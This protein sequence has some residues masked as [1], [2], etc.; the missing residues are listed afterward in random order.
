M[1]D[2]K[3]F[4]FSRTNTLNTYR[5]DPGGVINASIDGDSFV[6]A[7]ANG[8]VNIEMPGLGVGKSYLPG[9]GET[10][11]AGNVFRNLVISNTTASVV[12]IR[13]WAGF[14]TFIQH[15]VLYDARE[16]ASDGESSSGTI[17]AG[18]RA[19]LQPSTSSRYVRRKALYITN[20]SPTDPL[21]ICDAT[22]PAGSTEGIRLPGYETYI[23]TGSGAVN[24]TNPGGSAV[25]YSIFDLYYLTL[26]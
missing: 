17:N 2:T 5:I 13:L 25:S 4:Q 14:G 3:L 21:F 22:K 8:P 20:L 24:I 23:Y 16:A 18:G 10:L 11:P 9:E 7:S 12:T 19:I 1:D 15:P 26:A 6:L